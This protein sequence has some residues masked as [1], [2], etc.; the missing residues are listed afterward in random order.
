M[1][2][3]LGMSEPGAGSDLAS[4]R[5]RAG[6][7]RRRVHRQRAEG[8]DVRRPRRRRPA[9][10]CSHR[11]KCRQAQGHQRAAD[12]H[13][14][15]GSG[16]TAVRVVVRPGRPRLQRGVLQ[17]RAGARGEPRRPAERR[18]AGGQ[19]FARPRAE[20]VVAQLRRPLGRT[21]RG[22]PPVHRC[23]IGTG[24]PRW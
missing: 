23:W 3:S 20:H 13:R 22:L 5:T 6:A 12:S 15:S 19:R 9:D 10:F 16:P 4:L 17:R 14:P 21:G 1:T 18:L 8:V 2:A 24:T 11:S 7:G